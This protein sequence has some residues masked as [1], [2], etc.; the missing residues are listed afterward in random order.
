MDITF[1]DY[2]GNPSGGRSSM[3]GQ[4]E[5]AKAV[6][7]DKFNKMMMKSAGAIQYWLYKDEPDTY[8][9]HFKIPSESTDRLFYDVVIEFHTKD[10]VQKS[11]NKL[12]GYHVKFFSNDPNF[13]YTFA[14]VFKKN[15]LL[16]PQLE[17]KISEKFLKEKP[18]KTNP[19]TSVGYV[20][21]IYFAYL[22]FDAKGLFKKVAWFNAP[23]LKDYSF[24][25]MVMSADRKIA[26]GN[27][28]RQIQK[29][30]KKGSVNVG[31]SNL[32]LVAN[33]ARN[34]ATSVK[35]ANKV[36]TNNAKRSKYSSRTKTVNI[37]G[38]GRR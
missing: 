21:S 14:Y 27:N 38:R 24:A 33:N 32:D 18:K 30:T 37:I 29:A 5:A 16:I 34:V 9:V 35:V 3:V 20:K 4:K 7:N 25:H 17:S 22:L 15:K 28:L 36:V 26:Q 10:T 19:N 23:A 2:I 11:L 8:V 12:N 31:D 1:E 6:Y 13:C